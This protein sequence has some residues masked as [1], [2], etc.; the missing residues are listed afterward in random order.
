[1][2]DAGASGSQAGRALTLTVSGGATDFVPIAYRAEEAI[3]TPFL[4]T[5]D[6]YSPRSPLAPSDYLFQP[7]SLTVTR[8][9]GPKRH[10]N[11]MV[12]R[13]VSHGTALRDHALY[14]FEVVP[15]VWFLSQ[16]IDC[17][18]F[19]NATATD[20]FA[21]IFG[22]ISLDYE[23]RLQD[24][25]SARPY[26]TQFNETDLAF[27]TRI[28][29]EEGLYYCFEHAEHSHKMIILNY[30]RAF[31]PI[32]RGAM[33]F[34]PAGEN[35][36][37]ISSFRRLDATVY[38][39]VTI[40]DYDP[41]TI[42]RPRRTTGTL[43]QAQGAAQ[44]DVYLWPGH[45]AEADIIGKRARFRSE[46]A[47]AAA[48][49]YEAQGTHEGFF[50]GGTFTLATN[51]ITGNNDETFVVQAIE[52][53]FTDHTWVAGGGKIT[54]AN[55]FTAF[56][57]AN[58]WRQ[59]FGTPRPHLAGVYSALVIGAAGSEVDA[60]SLGRVKVRVFWD[61]R[62]S[63]TPDNA[64]WVRVVQPWSGNGWGWQHMPRVGTEVAVAFM[65]GDPDHPIVIGCFYNGSQ[66]PP[67][68]LPD[69]Q[70]RSG[71]RTRS[72][73][74]GDSST[75]SEFSIDDTAGKE[76]VLLH[77]EKDLTTEVEHDQSL[78]V[79]NC[80]TVTVRKDETVTIDRNQ[81]M[82]V[83]GD[84]SHTSEKSYTVISSNG[85]V[86]VNAQAESVKVNGARSIELVVGSMSSIKMEPASITL[87]V[88]ENSV[89]IDPS[90]I[91]I[92]GTMVKATAQAILDMKGPMASVSADGMLMLKGGL[93]NLN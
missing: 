89:K 25:L 21:T 67:F 86:V 31:P 32:D 85:N 45:T 59:P 58:T 20:I 11:G 63:T 75:Y 29:E 65:H 51:P 33:N 39:K 68:P 77:A 14:T 93:V 62:Q 2:S 69:Q 43:I 13:L 54:Y 26:T 28:I 6:F 80:R 49:L 42:N 10:F 37:M 1:M 78:T 35:Y 76:V 56:P 15:K 53:Q 91:A 71:I 79:N 70:T 48:A 61:H 23:C 60:E 5:I 18:I 12:R 88:G 72:S 38:G 84:V 4:L 17:R 44:R 90:G 41:V 92:S 22:E 73:T 55:R 64:I 87:T 57:A 7:V 19:P 30:N 46:A 34:S 66:K 52:H 74:S 81:T 24:Q 36:D 9:N 27:V 47:D 40:E 50:A 8:P 83:K 3:S 82:L 16:T